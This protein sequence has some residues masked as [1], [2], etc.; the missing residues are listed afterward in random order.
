VL[1]ST[2]SPS[3]SIHTG[4]AWGE[5]SARSVTTV[6]QFRPRRR[7]ACFSVSRFM[8]PSSPV[9]RGANA[10]RLHAVSR[11]RLARSL[12]RTARAVRIL[13]R[14]GLLPRPLRALALFGLLPVPGPFDEIVLLLVALVLAVFYRDRLRRAWHD[15][16]TQVPPRRRPV[17]PT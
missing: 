7:A 16:G 10:H 12:A 17:T 4:V 15:A 1:K 3:V 9:R 6:A 5:P 13:L 14:D 2:C 8:A 11:P